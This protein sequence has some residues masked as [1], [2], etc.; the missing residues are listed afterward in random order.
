MIDEN[1]D[2][3]IDRHEF[4][5]GVTHDGPYAHDIMQRMKTPKVG[6]RASGAGARL[7]PTSFF[8]DANSSVADRPRSKS[9]VSHE[10]CEYDGMNCTFKFARCTKCGRGEGALSSAPRPA[11]RGAS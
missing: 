3:V 4:T 8:N 10:L 2:G 6:G 9:P 1:A 11:S 5:E 7:A